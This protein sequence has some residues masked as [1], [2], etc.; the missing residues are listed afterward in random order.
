[1]TDEPAGAVAPPV[2][3]AAPAAPL[4]HTEECQLFQRVLHAAKAG[5]DDIHLRRWKE[6]TCCAC[7]CH[8]PRP[9]PEPR[10]RRTR[11]EAMP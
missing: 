11:K 7:W 10:R 4:P 9:T 8:V 1:M 3:P 6:L 5:L 2:T